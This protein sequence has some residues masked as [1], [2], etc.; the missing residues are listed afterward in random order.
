MIGRKTEAKDE[1]NDINLVRWY[2]LLQIIDDFIFI[3]HQSVSTTRLL[4]RLPVF[5]FDFI[6]FHGSA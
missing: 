4:G 6:Q 2:V 3:I 1:R 5:L